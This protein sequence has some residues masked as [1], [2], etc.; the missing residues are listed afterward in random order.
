MAGHASP[1]R[2]CTGA[3]LPCAV[4]SAAGACGGAC[5]PYRLH[6]CALRRGAAERL[7]GRAP[8]RLRAR[9]V[10]PMGRVP[11]HGPPRLRRGGRVAPASPI[12]VSAATPTSACAVAGH[13]SRAPTVRGGD[14]V[15]GSC[16]MNGGLFA[17][18][19]CPGL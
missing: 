4:V 17:L 7:P 15:G 8:L 14:C 16:V 19:C 5:M 10:R 12:G 3:E 2:G 18:G 13:A 6:L 1:I 11:Q 9:A